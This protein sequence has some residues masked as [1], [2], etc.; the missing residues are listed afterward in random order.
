[1]KLSKLFH[2]LYAFIMAIPLIIVPLYAIYLQNHTPEP[3]SV[4]LN[5]PHWVN[6]ILYDTE[7][8]DSYEDLHVNKIYSC[9]NFQIEFEEFGTFLD[10]NITIFQFDTL[11][12]Y[13]EEDVYI[14]E[15][16]TGYVNP[17]Y[18]YVDVSL[19]LSQVFDIIMYWSNGEVYIAEV[20]ENCDYISLGYVDFVIQDENSLSTFKTI[21]DGYVS[22]HYMGNFSASDLIIYNHEYVDDEPIIYNDT[23]IGSQFVYNLYNVVDKYFN[24]SNA[25]GLNNLYD[26]F[27]ANVFS[28]ANPLVFSVI[29]NLLVYWLFISLFWLIFD[30]L[31]YV[32]NMIHK[33]LD[34]ARLE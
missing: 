11:D 33:M 4:N 22:G 10:C 15:R 23:D 13:T 6:E 5:E 3:I 25:M 26:W 7:D 9:D 20:Y 31:M 8:V 16:L 24:W 12:I 34:K 30:V 14:D 18:A 17:N 21:C 27:I 1:M 28:A 29:F 2:T 32:P 19:S